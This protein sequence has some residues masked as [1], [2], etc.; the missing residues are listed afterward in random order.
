MITGV[1]EARRLVLAAILASDV[2]GS[3]QLMA[4]GERALLPWKSG[5]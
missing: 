5:R 3:S 2:A 4:E 1:P